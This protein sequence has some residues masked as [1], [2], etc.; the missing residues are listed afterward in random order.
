[1]VKFPTVT[2]TR[3]GGTTGMVLGAGFS[4]DM[5]T[6]G[7]G[8]GAGCGGGACASSHAAEEKSRRVQRNVICS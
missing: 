1:M 3:S 2:T 8:A 4:I 7:L 5:V 6:V